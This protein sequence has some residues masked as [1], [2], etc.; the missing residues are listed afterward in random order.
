MTDKMQTQISPPGIAEI[1]RA[2]RPIVSTGLPVSPEYNDCVLLGLRGVAARSVDPG[3]RLNRIK[4]LDDLLRRLLE[5]YHDD[6]LIESAHI[7]FG[8]SAGA[9]GKN[10]TKRRQSA[11]VQA[12][13][14]TDHFRKHIEPKILKQLAWQLHRDSQNYIPRTMATP[15]PLESSGDTPVIRKGD[16]SSKDIAEH[17]ELLSRLWADV[18]LLRAEILKVERLKNWPYEPTEPKLSEQKLEE[19]IADRDKV[20]H[21]AK[22]IIQR[23][24]DTYGQR[25]TH[26]EAT[27]NAEGLLRLAGWV[28][29]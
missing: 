22:I 5:S 9:R 18:Y 3:S 11:A 16:V 12:G 8:I 10:L 13:Y 4:A 14:E 29:G 25:I 26:G 1:M 19:A 21:V 6:E 15:P 7:L 23:Y 27:Y 17:E 24:L 20:L 28:E 2:L